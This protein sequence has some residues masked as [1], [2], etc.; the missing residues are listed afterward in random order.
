MTKS[1]LNQ[2]TN[3]DSSAP[4]SSRGRGYVVG[5][6]KRLIV[7]LLSLGGIGLL[8]YLDG[9]LE[10][11]SVSP[12]GGQGLSYGLLLLVGFFTGFHCV[13]MCGAL[14]VSYTVG[15]RQ[16]AS[17]G[18]GAHL[19][20]GC[21]K[22][23]S[24]TAIGALFGG[25]GAIVTFTP[26][27]R[28]IAGILAGVFLLLFG[29]SLLNIYAPLNR[30][31]FKTPGFLMRFIGKSVKKHSHPFVIGLF[32]G[33][34]I[35]CGPLQAMYVMAAGTGSPVEGASM[36]FVFGIG[37]LPVMM[38]FGALASVLSAHVA[39]KLIKASGI[40]VIALGAIMLNR[41]LAMSGS[42]YDFHTLS[43]RWLAQSGSKPAS[44]A[45]SR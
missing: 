26:Y 32:N 24:Y 25:L 35:I 20:Y 1:P 30:L 41:G 44:G 29:M 17:V 2:M 39:P 28:G 14:V 34:M 13:G 8:L 40:I 6:L 3:A 11:H 38:G 22:T 19:S 18:Y 21:G 27:M 45:S 16:R 4:P 31:R 23:L 9:M 12:L 10:Q 7:V 5:A 15:G 36:L 43:A 33:L 37:T 42:G